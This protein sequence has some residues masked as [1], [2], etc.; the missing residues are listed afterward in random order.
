MQYSYPINNQR[1]S[2]TGFRF[3]S[4]DLYFSGKNF[5]CFLTAA[6]NGTFDFDKDTN[7]VLMHAQGYGSG[8]NS[9]FYGSF[10]FK[11][12]LIGSGYTYYNTPYT[13]SSSAASNFKV[14]PITKQYCLIISNHDN[15]A[16]KGLTYCEMN[17]NTNIWTKTNI[18]PTARQTARINLDFKNNGYPI[19]AYTTIS[20]STGFLKIAEYDGSNWTKTVIHSG[21]YGSNVFYEFDFKYNSG[22][23][24]YGAT[25]ID[26]VTYSPNRSGFY[27]TN[28]GGIIKKYNWNQSGINSSTN[29]LFFK[30]YKGETTPFILTQKSS[31]PYTDFIYLKNENFVTGVFISNLNMFSANKE[32]ILVN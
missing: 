9:S 21:A 22:E 13:G 6:Y 4:G 18:E 16:D 5:P 8:N 31:S 23:N 10:I 24:Y 3:P 26:S 14:N 19:T 27:I 25:F 11:K 2:W 29:R 12:D 17:P 15:T 30:E 1:T 7:Q 20:G 28:K 32:A